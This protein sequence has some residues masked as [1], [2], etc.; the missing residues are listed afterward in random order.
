MSSKTL[1]F[2][3]GF[4]SPNDGDPKRALEVAKKAGAS[5]VLIDDS[6]GAPSHAFSKFSGLRLE[7][8]T[9]VV[10]SA[11]ATN[12]EVIAK[13]LEG[14]GSPAIFILREDAKKSRTQ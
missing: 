5:G 3:L 2:I 9:L 4:Y 12:V 1:H 8:E 14:T 13:A 11:G 7:G 10:A 6:S